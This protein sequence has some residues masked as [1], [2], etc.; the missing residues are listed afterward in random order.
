MDETI[1]EVDDSALN[2]ALEREN[3]FTR[4]PRITQDSRVRAAR[5]RGD[6]AAYETAIKSAIK[7]LQKC[8][9]L[10]GSEVVK[11]EPRPSQLVENAAA[12]N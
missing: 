7:K 8:L 5:E 12:A 4:D 2:A 3:L 11:S 9:D 10:E 6:F 1:N